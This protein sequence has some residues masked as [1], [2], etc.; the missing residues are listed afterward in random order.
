M[1][2]LGFVRAALVLACAGALLTAAQAR[3]P[4]PAPTPVRAGATTGATPREP[5]RIM[6]LGASSTV[7]TGSASTAGYRGPLQQL[8]AAAG[9]PVELVGSQQ[10]GPPTVPDRDHEGHAGWTMA[11][12]LPYVAGW[13]RAAD[14]DVVLLHVGTNDLLQGVPAAVAAERLDALLDTVHEASDAHVVVAGVWAPLPGRRVERA[15][16]ARRAAEVVAGHRAEGRAVSFADTGNLLDRAE[17]S[18][19]LHPN[20]EGYRRIAAMWVTQIRAA[21]R[22]P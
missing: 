11:R 2:L 12:M 20:A 17:L 10:D 18:D 15:E 9:V 6:P 1:K 19:G 8:M 5:V 21:L 7:G 3:G 14:P 16:F 13:V 4:A 22:R